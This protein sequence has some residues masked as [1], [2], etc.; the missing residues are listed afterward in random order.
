MVEED[1]R[2]REFNDVLVE[3]IEESISEILGRRALEALYVGLE[4]RYDVKRDEVPYRIETAFKILSDTFGT[5]GSQILGMRVVRRLYKK[6]NLPLYESPSRSF[7]K[8]IE[9][10]KNALAQSPLDESAA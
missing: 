9:N 2:F 4:K 7:S 1:K 6:L 3:A 10:A 5:K 8:Y